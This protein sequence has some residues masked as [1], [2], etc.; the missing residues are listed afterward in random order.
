MS[1]LNWALLMGAIAIVQSLRAEYN[2][3]AAIRAE[4]SAKDQYNSGYEDGDDN[5]YEKSTEAWRDE[6][7]QWR[8]LI[9]GVYRNANDL[10]PADDE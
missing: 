10:G 5:S 2:A 4:A 1:D 6:A 7:L 9:I 8:N 3:R